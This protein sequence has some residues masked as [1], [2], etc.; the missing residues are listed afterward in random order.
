M[1]DNFAFW[2]SLRGQTG[3][4]CREIIDKPVILAGTQLPR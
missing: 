1:K 3:T 4:N 2:R